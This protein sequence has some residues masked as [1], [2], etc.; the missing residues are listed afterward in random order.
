MHYSKKQSTFKYTVPFKTSISSGPIP[1]NLKHYSMPVL[2]LLFIFLIHTNSLFS[3]TD[4]LYQNKHSPFYNISVITNDGKK[5][6]GLFADVQDSSLSIYTGTRSE[7]K[8][9]ELT[10]LNINELQL[11]TLRKRNRVAKGILNMGKWG[12]GILCVSRLFAKS[13]RYNYYTISI[14]PVSVIAG[15]ILGASRKKRI[16]LNKN[17]MAFLEV[18]SDYY[19]HY[20][21]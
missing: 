21:H 7:W 3:Q 12:M 8:V 18:R 5:I 4:S 16:H 1:V 9:H 17:K 11:V 20:D 2:L 19:E 15:A 13:N 14:L 6:K 10:A